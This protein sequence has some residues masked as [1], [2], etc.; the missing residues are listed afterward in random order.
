[1]NKTLK[2][3][4]V[5][6]TGSLL[7]AL[8]PFL[9][10][11]VLIRSTSQSEFGLVMLLI[12]IGTV[13]SFG[14]SLG[15][16]AVLSRELIFDENR[17][18]HLKKLSSGYQTLMI[19][20]AAIIY[21][22][23]LFVNFAPSLKIL[24]LG[25]VLALSLAGIQIKLSVLRAEFK[26]SQ[27]A[28][29]AIASTAIPL[30]AITILPNF[31]NVDLYRTY[32]GITL[33]VLLI[34]NISNL[35]PKFGLTFLKDTKD[36]VRIGYPIIFHGIAISLFQYGDKIASY[37]GIGAELVSQVVIISLFMTA[38]MLLLSTI[39]NA[40]LP[41]S[42][43][44]FKKSSENG[45]SYLHKTS[46]N[47][48]L[49][50]TLVCMILIILSK[51]LVSIFVPDNYNLTEITRAIVIGI[52]FTPLYVL[53]LQN[54]HLLTM[55]KRFKSLGKITPISA[56]IQFFFTFGLISLIG[57]KAPAY[58]LLIAISIQVILT[59]ISAKSFPNL[60][61]LP[62]YLTGSLSAFSF[63]CLNFFF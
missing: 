45:F 33:L 16:P 55:N 7:Q 5:Y 4:Y 22:I 49:F 12:S 35:F 56:L 21:F 17:S 3:S 30:I 48:T 9:V 24:F 11:P 6:I 23:T 14:F 54:T 15:I 62:L 51:P 20:F 42:L 32:S 47:L 8:I 63:I 41:A 43:E 50:I 29:L 44:S 2:H 18:S 58:G 52:S 13:L 34:T 19:W 26:S 57:L 27:F 59:T 40:W 31:L 25:F 53:Y 28:F 36:L 37:L 46:Q 1:M 60:N 10:I 39:N 61:K 38:P